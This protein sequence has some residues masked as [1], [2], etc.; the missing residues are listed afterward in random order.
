MPRT[1][2]IYFPGALLHVFNR[3]NEKKEIFISDED[4]I[5]FLYILKN[6]LSEFNFKIYAYVLMPNHFHLLIKDE[7]GKLPYIMKYI[8]ENYTMYFNYK[9]KRV[10]HLFQGR[11][12]SILVEEIYLKHVVRYIILNPVRSGLT[13]KLSDYKWSSYYEYTGKNKKFKL[14]TTDWILSVFCNDREKAVE[15]FK[16]FLIEQED[17]FSNVIN[18]SLL[19][20][21]ILGSHKFKENFQN[22]LKFNKLNLPKKIFKSIIE[23]EKIIKIVA[24]LFKINENELKLKRG[25]YNYLKKTTIYI[26]KEYTN[27]TI[28]NIAKVF[29]IH[30]TSV[31][32]VYNSV[33]KEKSNNEYLNKILFEIERQI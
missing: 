3:G 29:D 4:R 14:T 2:R 27:L 6:S 17:I 11:Y 9:Y 13:E 21:I 20:N 22:K 18:E 16:N 28:D 19:S 5:K 15:N 10:G 1:K 26:M 25:K 30:P 23:P 8:L 32:K 24:Q 31:S 33:K 12:K 7:D